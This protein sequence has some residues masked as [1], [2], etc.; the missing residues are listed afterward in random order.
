LS[1]NCLNAYFALLSVS[2]PVLHP[3]H[4]TDFH[5]PVSVDWLNELMKKE[6]RMKYCVVFFTYRT[7]QRQQTAG[8]IRL[9]PKTRRV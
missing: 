2:G 5:I 8:L 3:Y 4:Q 6:Y 9:G 7:L 1:K